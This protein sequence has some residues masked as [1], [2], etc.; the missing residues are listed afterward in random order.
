MEWLL[1]FLVA[2]ALGEALREIFSPFV[3]FVEEY[4][5]AIERRFRARRKL[6]A[7]LVFGAFP[8]FFV[9]TTMLLWLLQFISR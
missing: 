8:V 9:V 2:S 7:I 3:A 4:I 1:L 5:E 6:R